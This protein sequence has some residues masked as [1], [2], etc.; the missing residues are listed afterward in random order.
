MKDSVNYVYVV[1]LDFP[2]GKRYL[3]TSR[4]TVLSVD[5]AAKYV[6]RNN[7]AAAYRRSEFYN[8]GIKAEFLVY[9]KKTGRMIDE[10]EYKE[11]P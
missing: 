4:C 5:I 7:A 2:D 10:V 11:E 1:M 9:N 6:T 3:Y 8:C